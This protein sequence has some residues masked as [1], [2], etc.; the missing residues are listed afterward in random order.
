MNT[1]A[2]TGWAV[3]EHLPTGRV[4]HTFADEY[5]AMQFAVSV[6]STA[7]PYSVLF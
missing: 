6:G 2:C 4:L 1:H 5:L 7:Q 3:W